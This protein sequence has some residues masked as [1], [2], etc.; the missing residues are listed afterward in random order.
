MSDGVL[1]DRETVLF[2]CLYAGGALLDKRDVAHFDTPI[3]VK[4][5]LNQY[6]MLFASF[7]GPLSVKCDQTAATMF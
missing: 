1:H 3:R 4:Q 2:V 5:H 6:V 7:S